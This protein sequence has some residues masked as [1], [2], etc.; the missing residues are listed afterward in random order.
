MIEAVNITKYFDEI[1]V[2]DNISFK[3][4]YSILVYN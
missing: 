3:I 2:L 4:E 1:K